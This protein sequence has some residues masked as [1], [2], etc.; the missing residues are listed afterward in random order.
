[1][2]FSGVFHAT[3][4]CWRAYEVYSSL[5]IW[6]ITN[7]VLCSCSLETLNL[8]TVVNL[9]IKLSLGDVGYHQFMVLLGMG[10]LWGWPHDVE[11]VE[12]LPGFL[13]LKSEGQPGMRRS[14]DAKASSKH[15][16][17]RL[18]ACVWGWFFYVSLVEDGRWFKTW[19]PRPCACLESNTSHV[20][21][22]SA[23][24]PGIPKLFLTL[25]FW[26]VN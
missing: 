22:W 17:R 3:F 10:F 12:S 11:F 20:A 26:L 5:Y 2:C 19:S 14:W 23:L 15:V 4:D 16:F 18:G 9:T 21:L 7:I 25:K 6:G 24:W 8:S 1:M 13:S